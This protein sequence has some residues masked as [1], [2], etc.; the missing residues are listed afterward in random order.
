MQQ[1]AMLPPSFIE[2]RTTYI[3]GRT[4]IL[5]RGIPELPI[6][7]MI[8]LIVLAK[9]SITNVCL[10]TCLTGRCDAGHACDDIIWDD[11]RDIID[12]ESPTMGDGHPLF[13][14][15]YTDHCIWISIPEDG[16]PIDIMVDPY[17]YTPSSFT[18]SIAGDLPSIMG[19]SLKMQIPLAI[20]GWGARPL[21]DDPVPSYN[22][23]AH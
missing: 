10:T 18:R 5:H 17:Y 20:L 19:A 4:G 1:G 9:G 22:C 8:S 2:N 15:G 13:D 12:M 14:R 7:D 23:F 16:V 21:A 6:N 3:V 11:D